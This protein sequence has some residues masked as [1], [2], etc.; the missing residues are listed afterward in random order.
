MLKRALRIVLCLGSRESCRSVFRSEGII[1]LYSIYV[2]EVL[3][4]VRNNV[5]IINS[6]TRHR[7]FDTRYGSN[8]EYLLHWTQLHEARPLYKGLVL[9]NKLPLHVCNYNSKDFAGYI[10][11]FEH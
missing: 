10:I 9:Y 3:R 6:M 1:T 5:H 11:G 2:T 7:T 8:L 4:L